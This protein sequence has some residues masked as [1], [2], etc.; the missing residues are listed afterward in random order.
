MAGLLHRYWKSL[1]GATAGGSL[2]A[3]YALFIGCHST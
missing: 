1:V 2:G 3:A